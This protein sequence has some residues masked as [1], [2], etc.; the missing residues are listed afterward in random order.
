MVSEGSIE[1]SSFPRSA[2]QGA[3]EPKGSRQSAER[4]VD[5]NEIPYT[6]EIEGRALE[7]TDGGA[8]A[9]KVLISAFVFEA[10]LWGEYSGETT[11]AIQVPV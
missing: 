3:S 10:V 5:E 6:S 7:P 1:L 8:S 9:W 11:S 2:T 4:Q